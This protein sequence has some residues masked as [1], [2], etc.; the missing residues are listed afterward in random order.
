ML[1]NRLTPRGCPL[2]ANSSKA[3]RRVMGEGNALAKLFGRFH[4]GNYDPVGANIE[5][6][7]NKTDASLGQSHKN[8]SVAAY[9]GADMAG[10]LLP[11]QRTMFGINDN[12]VD[13]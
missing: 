2:R 1:W 10:D 12:P 13:A 9:G 3:H 4:P 8:N 5:C 7:L 11:V 6:T